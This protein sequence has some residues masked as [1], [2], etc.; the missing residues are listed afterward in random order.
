MYPIVC[1]NPSV[2]RPQ[3]SNDEYDVMEEIEYPTIHEI[4]MKDEIRERGYSLSPTGIRKNVPSSVM[5][6]KTMPPLVDRS[7]KLAAIK[8]YDENQK[9]LTEI[10]EKQDQLMQK[11]DQNDVQLKQKSKELNL[12]LELKQKNA[13]GK[14]ELTESEENLMFNLMEL[15]SRAK[16][17]VSSF[18]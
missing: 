18:C 9:P 16:D 12:I 15:E 3:S 14:Q 2:Q 7:S 4:T 5:G 1:T 6:N 13:N 11:A 17:Y 8:T 10:K